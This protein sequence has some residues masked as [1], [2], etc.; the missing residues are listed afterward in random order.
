M[1][2]PKISFSVVIPAHN[3]SRWIK[4]A[5]NSVFNQDLMPI[6]VFVIDDNSQDNLGESIKGFDVKYYKV[7]FK[8]A[9]ATRNHVKDHV[10]GDYIAFLDADDIWFPDHLSRASGLLQIH[11]NPA[12]YINYFD[13]LDLEDKLVKRDCPWD[14]NEE[15]EMM[16]SCKYSSFYTKFKYFVGMSACIVNAARFKEIGGFDVDF[17]KRHDI[18]MWWRLIHGKSCIIDKH[19]SS[20]YRKY[21]PGSVSQNSHL[22]E[23]FKLKGLLKNAPLYEECESYQKN[24][25]IAAISAMNQALLKGDNGLIQKI[26][27]MGVESWGIKEKIIFGTLG[28]FPLA[29]RLLYSTLK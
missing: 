14:L 22:T 8:N 20:A 16:S 15:Y 5:L 28:R 29:Y 3:S 1:N 19:K 18:E 4:E 11:E 7:N 12:G 21:V 9:A 13:L 24:I 10:S 17:Q 27:D 2:S 6:E 25:K 23:Y 26:R